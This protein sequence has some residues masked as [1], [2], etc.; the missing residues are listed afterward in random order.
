MFNISNHQ[1]NV[2]RYNF[3]PVRIKRQKIT[4][5]EKVEL[6]HNVGGI[7]TTIMEN[8]MEAPQKAKTSMQYSTLDYI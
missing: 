8:N 5:V 2:M 6:L 3:T 4:S 7:R 1:G